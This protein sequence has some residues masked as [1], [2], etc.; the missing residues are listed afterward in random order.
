MI[1][2]CSRAHASRCS[3]D[4][5]YLDLDGDVI[6]CSASAL[7]PAG[8]APQRR[9]V[10][11]ARADERRR[12]SLCSP[13]RAIRSPRGN[14]IVVLEAMKMQHEIGAERDGTVGEILVK[15]GDQVATRQ[16]LAELAPEP[17]QPPRPRE[18]DA[19]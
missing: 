13:N 10:A 3:D 5:L 18:E 14:A 1:P 6:E 12:S 19:S 9:L 15:P 8:V 7:A 2:A 4:V 11:A 16:V 17:G